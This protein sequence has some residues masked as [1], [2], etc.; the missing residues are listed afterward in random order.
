MAD[1]AGLSWVEG[2]E[3]WRRQLVAELAS[4]PETLRLFREGIDNFQRI[5]KR[6]LDASESIEQFTRLYAGA[7]ADG[8]RRMEEAGN[9]LRE[10]MTASP[11]DPVRSAVSDVAKALS[12]MAELNPLWPLRGGG[13]PESG[14]EP[15]P[16]RP[17]EHTSPEHTGPAPSATKPTP[18][19]K[20]P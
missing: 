10:Q 18:R 7:M 16:E 8:R 13:S 11:A 19:R 4:L 1:Q 6:L 20:T 2:I 3:Q 14:P 17:P 9:A 15:E 12:A 5:T